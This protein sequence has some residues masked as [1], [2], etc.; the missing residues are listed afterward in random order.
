MYTEESYFDVFPDAT[1]EQYLDYVLIDE[2]ECLKQVEKEFQTKVIGLRRVVIDEEYFS[3]IKK[4]KLE[5]TMENRLL[6]ME[7]ISDGDMERLWDKHNLRYLTFIQYLPV[8]MVTEKV[9]P[10]Q[11]LDISPTLE[12]ELKEVIRKVENTSSVF[13]HPQLMRADRLDEK[14]ENKF[15]EK[16]NLYFTMKMKEKMVIKPMLL[17]QK[18]INMDIRFI[19]FSVYKIENPLLTKKEL[20]RL[21]NSVMTESMARRLS[22]LFSKELSTGIQSFVHEFFTIE[23]MEYRKEA[24]AVMKETAEK[25]KVSFLSI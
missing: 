10:V 6:Y 5:N 14:F 9:L 13:I 19:P 16:S 25:N 8:S 22:T 1:E 24:I 3:W 15:F 18:K 17:E 7:A 20:I 2:L 12:K 4:K 21:D 23:P 11:N